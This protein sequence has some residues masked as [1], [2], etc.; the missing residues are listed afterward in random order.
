MSKESKKTKKKLRLHWKYHRSTPPVNS[1][2]ITHLRRRRKEKK[3]WQQ[4]KR[5]E[6]NFF[7]PTGRVHLK[8]Q[9]RV[10]AN[11]HIFKS[12]LMFNIFELFHV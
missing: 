7:L 11:Q 10:T 5:N 6:K 2:N 4:K 1:Y 9:T 3:S 8:Q 12:G